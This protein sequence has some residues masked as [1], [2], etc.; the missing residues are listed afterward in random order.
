MLANVRPLAVAASFALAFAL[1]SARA[2]GGEPIAGTSVQASSLA[3]RLF[4]DGKALA[5]AGDQEGACAKFEASLK[6]DPRAVGTL[7]N[8]AMCKEATGKL[9]TAWGLYREVATRSRGTRADR[10]EL[11]EKK[12]RELA[13]RLST[14]AIEVPSDHPSGMTVRID[15]LVLEEGAWS[16]ALPVDAGEHVVEASAPRFV[17]SSVRVKVVGERQRVPVKVPR[18]VAEPAKKAEAPRSETP[19][20]PPSHAARNV[21]IVLTA[22]GVVALGV[23]GAFGVDVLA[24]ADAPKKACPAPCIDGSPAAADSQSRYDALGREALVTNIL[25]PVGGAV[26]LAG[27]YLWLVAGSSAAPPKATGARVV[28]GPGSAAVVGAF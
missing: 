20:P 12:E 13:P 21:G 27:L 24:R 3:E 11:A 1:A 8:I 9:A 2:H 18:L 4:Q 28:V 26:T 23:G 22:A 5:E 10:V 25:L 15:G 19:T 14:L 7:L 16:S 6:L 17:A